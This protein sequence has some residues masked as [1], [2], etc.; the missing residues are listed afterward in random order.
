M[1]M[2]RDVAMT[3]AN[4][5]R[6]KI[7]DH[8]ASAVKEKAIE[9]LILGTVQGNTAPNQELVHSI[10]LGIIGFPYASPSPHMSDNILDQNNVIP[11]IIQR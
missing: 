11:Y 9:C 8:A 10:R 6:R 1:D 2:L 3:T 5:C 7:S 4:H